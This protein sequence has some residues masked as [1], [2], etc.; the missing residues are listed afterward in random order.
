MRAE[1][2]NPSTKY[3]TALKNEN[4]VSEA[5]LVVLKPIERSFD[6]CFASSFFKL[7]WSLRVEASWI[8]KN[9]SLSTFHKVW[10]I[11]LV[12]LMGSRNV[13]IVQFPK[14]NTAKKS[15]LN[16]HIVP[17]P[18]NFKNCRDSII[19]LLMKYPIIRKIYHTRPC[20]WRDQLV[21]YADSQWNNG[22]QNVRTICT[23]NVIL[24][25]FF[26]FLSFF[27]FW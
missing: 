17:S 20:L 5:D 16:N 10:E 23:K 11:I 13:V 21:W 25:W 22:S 3:L 8:I 18:T 7:L 4:K 14:K 1:T 12:I 24:Q 27:R 6:F 9:T 26:F 19:S 2:P 15:F